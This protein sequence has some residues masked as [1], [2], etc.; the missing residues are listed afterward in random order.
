MHKPCNLFEIQESQERMR[1]RAHQLQGEVGRRI[2]EAGKANSTVNMAELVDTIEHL[3]VDHCF[4]DEIAAAMRRICSEELEFSSSDDL[5]VVA[6]RFGLLR[7]HGIWVSADVF[8]KF[9]DSNGN[10]STNLCKNPRGLLTLYNAAHMAIPGEKTLDD[11]IAFSRRHLEA[12][13]GKLQSPLAEQVSR[14]LGI[15]L[16]R[17]GRPVENMDFIADYEQEAA[18]DVTLLE[19][20]KLDFELRRCCYLEELRELT[21]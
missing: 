11:A 18:H 15:P 3:G 6:L 14:A 13:K 2:F 21:L 5:H 12:M 9:K 4:R 20:A 1:E 19:L 17:I 8:D 7:Q 16:H 10:F